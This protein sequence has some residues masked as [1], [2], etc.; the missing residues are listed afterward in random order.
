[1]NRV[2]EVPDAVA[3]LG[4][5]IATAWNARPVRLGEKSVAR[6]FLLV[7]GQR[8]G[9][10]IL[11][12]VLSTSPEIVL[13][14]EV[15][16]PDP[17]LSEH[18]RFAAAAGHRRPH[19]Y[20]EAEL[21]LTAFLSHLRRLDPWATL[22]GFDI[23]YSQFHSITP[24]Y[25][26]LFFPPVLIQFIR[27][28]EIP[29]LHAVRENLVRAILSELVA[30]ARKIWHHTGDERIAAPVPIDCRQLRYKLDERAANQAIFA[31]LMA[32]HRA[33]MTCEFEWFT[34]GLAM[35]DSAGVL[36][37]SDNPFFHIADFL[38]VPR[39]LKDPGTLHKI[40]RA[41]YAEIIANYDEVRLVIADSAYAKFLGTI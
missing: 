35:K 11:R 34:A 15:F 36:E 4:S 25:A 33:M 27:Q 30:T 1:M 13:W 16:T 20:T 10:N 12:T 37:G 23:K 17:D 7:G 5:S 28:H 19:D 39:N 24:R 31:D 14:G 32:G 9:T 21:Q 8:T 29:V 6:P 22:Y 26:P 18:D 2:H 41:P 40:I 38:G 3:G